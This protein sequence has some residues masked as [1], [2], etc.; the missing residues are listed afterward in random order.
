MPFAQADDGV[1]IAFGTFALTVRGPAGRGSRFQVTLSEN[2]SR[3][4][5]IVSYSTAEWGLIP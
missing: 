1:R 4:R 2:G 5:S 3:D